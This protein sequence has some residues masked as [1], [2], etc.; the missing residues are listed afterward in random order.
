MKLLTRSTDYAVRA[1]AYL[2][3]KGDET[4]TVSE[5]VERL[6]IPRPFLRKILQALDRAGI[7]SSR[8]G[9]SGG[10]RLSAAAD[11]IFLADLIRIFQGPFKLNECLFKKVV[12][13]HRRVC[14]LKKRIDR[15]EKRL[16]LELRD[17]TIKDLL[18]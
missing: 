4:V 6:R 14:G 15:M 1:L 12:C 10:F 9:K 7:L 16:V 3:K 11:R 8:K 17:V 2:A 18:E 5:L 13:P